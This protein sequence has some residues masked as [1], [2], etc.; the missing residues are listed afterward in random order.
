MEDNYGDEVTRIWWIGFKGEIQNL[1][2]EPVEVLYEKAA[3][4]KDHTLIQGIGD[5]AT[6]GSRQGM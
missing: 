2:R 1:S 4:P 5:M 3:N 6:S